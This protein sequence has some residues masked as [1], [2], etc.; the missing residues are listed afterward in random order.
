[1]P[2]QPAPVDAQEPGHELVILE[3]QVANRKSD[4]QLLQ[5]EATIDAAMCPCQPADQ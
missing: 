2:E 5:L 4:T 1:M 3:E